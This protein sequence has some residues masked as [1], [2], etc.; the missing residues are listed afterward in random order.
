MSRGLGEHFWPTT[1][2][3]THVDFNLVAYYVQLWYCLPQ[4]TVTMF[5]FLLYVHILETFSST[6]SHGFWGAFILLAPPHI[7]SSICPLIPANPP[8]AIFLLA[9]YILE[10]SSFPTLPSYVIPVAILNETLRSK[11]QS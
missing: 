8:I 1:Q 5:N 6:R 7:P 4:Y 2:D 10:E 3:V 9:L 11:A